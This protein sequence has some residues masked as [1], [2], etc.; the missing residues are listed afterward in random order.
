MMGMKNAEGETPAQE[1]SEGVESPAVEAAEMKAAQ[2]KP[3][4][5]HTSPGKSMF[6]VKPGDHLPH[7]KHMK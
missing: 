1:K 3:T 2:T 4:S 5:T 7:E 6:D